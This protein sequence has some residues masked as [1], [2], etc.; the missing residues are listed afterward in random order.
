[1]Y[2]LVQLNITNF[3]RTHLFAKIYTLF[4]TFRGR[5]QSSFWNR[6]ASRFLQLE[7]SAITGTNF[8]IL[9]LAPI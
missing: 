9:A 1:M 3:T 6:T 7:V 4:R 5:L 2:Y 8:N